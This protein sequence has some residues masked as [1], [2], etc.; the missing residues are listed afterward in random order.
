MLMKVKRRRLKIFPEA[1]SYGTS[2]ADGDA[3]KKALNAW[4]FK[5]LLRRVEGL[6]SITKDMFCS[7]G[8]VSSLL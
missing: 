5:A 4:A 7:S 1:A 6:R 2:V 8:P 3:W